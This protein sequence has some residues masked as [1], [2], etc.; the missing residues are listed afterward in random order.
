M[1]SAVSRIFVQKNVYIIQNKNLFVLK[2]N[3]T[4]VEV[5]EVKGVQIQDFFVSKGISIYFSNATGLYK[6]DR[7]GKT[8]YL[9]SNKFKVMQIT[10]DYENGG[11]FFA[12]NDGIYMDFV[13][14]RTV[15]RVSDIKRAFGI[16]FWNVY[17]KRKKRQLIYSDN[18]GIYALRSSNHSKFCLKRNTSKSHLTSRRYT[19]TTPEI[20]FTLGNNTESEFILNF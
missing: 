17:T 13:F 3:N 8:I 14:K 5:A 15:R 20:S 18:H 19:L 7:P 4:F 1:S 12:T 16:A 10:E 11:V 2:K 9:L 6:V